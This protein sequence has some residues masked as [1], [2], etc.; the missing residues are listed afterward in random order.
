MAVPDIL[1][2]GD[3]RRIDAWK[4]A[5]ARARTENRRTDLLSS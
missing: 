2:S 1:L 4:K 3:H 5:A